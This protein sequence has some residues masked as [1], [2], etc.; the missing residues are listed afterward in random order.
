M[1]CIHLF[2]VLLLSCS[3]VACATETAPAPTVREDNTATAPVGKEPT[4]VTKEDLSATPVAI[5]QVHSTDP[6]TASAEQQPAQEVRQVKDAATP[7]KSLEALEPSKDAAQAENK[8]VVVS[9]PAPKPKE[10]TLAPPTAPT[11]SSAPAA[12]PDQ[13]PTLPKAPDHGTWNSLLQTHVT[14]TGKVNYAGFKRDGAKLDAYLAS[15]SAATPNAEWS[16]QEAMAYWINAYNAF[17]IKRILKDY[18]L[19]SITDLDGG[20]PWK[21]KWIELGGKKY[22]LNNIEHDILRPKY[23]DARIHFAVNCAATS[24]PPLPNK[25]FT[26]ENLNSMLQSGTR[27]F[28]RNSAYNQ[29][30][31]DIKVS[32][33]FEWYGEDFGD[34]RAYLNKYLAAPLPADKEIGFK[35]YDWGLNKQ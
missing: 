19:K 12:A 27:K 6:A 18:P 24:C 20:D 29:T 14:S 16:R 32:K 3:L 7:A 15:L 22:S 33:I 10:E 17:T 26:A 25:A 2:L 1:P 31:G 8:P 21:V 11:T 30:N 34:L 9:I 23:K 4:A 28:I 13:A 35:E 5:E